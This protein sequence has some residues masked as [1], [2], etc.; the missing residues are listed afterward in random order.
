LYVQTESKATNKASVHID[1]SFP[2]NP[3]GP[4]NLPNFIRSCCIKSTFTNST[5][6]TVYICWEE[7]SNDI[8]LVPYSGNSIGS[9]Q[10]FPI[11]ELLDEDHFNEKFI[12]R[13][14]T[15]LI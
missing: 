8:Y 12:S 3:P 1:D 11:Q 9:L 15:G 14:K 5:T 6:K 4:R 10:K 7:K 13:I 2:P